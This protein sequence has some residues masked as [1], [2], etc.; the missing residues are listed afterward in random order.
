MASNLTENEKDQLIDELLNVIFCYQK[1]LVKI[2]DK[3]K[4]KSHEKVSD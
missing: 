1:I 2:F 3:L 4:E